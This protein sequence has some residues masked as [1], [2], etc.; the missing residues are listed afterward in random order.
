MAS[1]KAVRKALDVLQRIS[2]ESGVAVANSWPL[3]FCLV[4]DEEEE[5]ESDEEP[6]LHPLLQLFVQSLSPVSRQLTVRWLQRS[7]THIFALPMEARMQAAKCIWRY[8]NGMGYALGRRIPFPAVSLEGVL[9]TPEDEIDD[10]L[11]DEYDLARHAFNGYALPLPVGMVL[12]EGRR[13]NSLDGDDTFNLGVYDADIT[14]A[15]FTSTSWHPSGALAHAVTTVYAS[16]VPGESIM[17]ALPIESNIVR[18]RKEGETPPWGVLL[19]HK[20]VSPSVLAVDPAGDEELRDEDWN[21]E[22]EREIILQPFVRFHYCQDDVAVLPLEHDR[23]RGVPVRLLYIHVFVEDACPL[24]MLR[25][26]HA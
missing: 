18:A 3:E 7:R 5:E 12:F 17:G 24:C 8:T 15:R 22:G 4:D 9:E 25:A 1:H 2:D 19:V 26:Q 16:E 20:I 21:E 14:R 10:N 6:R 11:A 13:G 23:F